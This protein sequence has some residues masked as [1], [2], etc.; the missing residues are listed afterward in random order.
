MGPKWFP[1]KSPNFY[2]RPNVRFDWFQGTIVPDLNPSQLKP[3]DDGTKNY[4]TLFVTDFVLL[5]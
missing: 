2:I 5:F 4:Q 3:Y 1:T